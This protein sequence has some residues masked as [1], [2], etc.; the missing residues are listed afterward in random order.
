MTSAVPAA[1]DRR[2]RVAEVFGG[3]SPE[4]AISCLSA[5]SILES[6]DRDRYDVVAVG[7]A[8]DGRWVLA[9]DDPK[10]LAAS[11]RQLPAVD[12]SSCP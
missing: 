8:A 9:P 2:L 3:R 11:G 1:S 10:K 6:M 5:G 4:H 12:P 7:I